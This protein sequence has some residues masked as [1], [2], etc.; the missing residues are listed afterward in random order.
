MTF[1]FFF[2]PGLV[3]ASGRPGPGSTR[4]VGFQNY[5]YIYI[6]ISKQTSNKFLSFFNYKTPSRFGSCQIISFC[7]TNFI[8]SLGLYITSFIIPPFVQPSK[9]TFF[10]ILRLHGI[11]LKVLERFLNFCSNFFFFLTWVSGSAYAHL[12]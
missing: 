12:D 11:L 8:S 10:V 9:Q 5:I 3:L 4:R 7:I 1:S 2:Q 6:Y